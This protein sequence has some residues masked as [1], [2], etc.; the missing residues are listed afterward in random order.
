MANYQSQFTGPQVDARLAAVNN[1]PWALLRSQDEHQIDVAVQGTWYAYVNGSQLCQ[2][3][4]LW[5]HNDTEDSLVYA[6]PA[7]LAHRMQVTFSIA[8]GNNNR[9]EA[10]IAIAPAGD[11]INPGA[12]VRAT[13]IRPVNTVGLPG[14]GGRFVAGV[15]MDCA[16]IV[17]GDRVYAVFRNTSGTTNMEVDHMTLDILVTR[18]LP[19]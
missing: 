17:P 7:G 10:G 3:S 4:S 1:N 5:S 14:G 2:T 13:S 18:S 15:S 9:V 12:Q 8:S 19:A 11:A 6:G 16:G